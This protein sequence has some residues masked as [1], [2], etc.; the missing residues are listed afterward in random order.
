M[1]REETS[2][3]FGASPRYSL[4]TGLRTSS[5]GATYFGRQRADSQSSQ[6]G[7]GNP[8][9]T[10]NPDPNLTLIPTFTLTLTRTLTLAE[11]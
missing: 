9:P 1:N 11:P 10:P 4:P 5:S 3:Q 7:G 8:S 6:K 2:A